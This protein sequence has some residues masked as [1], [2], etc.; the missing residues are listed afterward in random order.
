MESEKLHSNRS[1][2]DYKNVILCRGQCHRYVISVIFCFPHG[3]V[4]EDL[5]ENLPFMLP[6][7]PTKFSNLY[8]NLIELTLFLKRNI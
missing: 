4:E 2:T 8:K 7:Q 6:W 1:I 3:F 5:Y